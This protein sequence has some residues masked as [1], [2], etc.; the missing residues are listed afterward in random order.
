MPAKTLP[1]TTEKREWVSCMDKLNTEKIKLPIS[2]AIKAINITF[3]QAGNRVLF[4]DFLNRKK[5]KRKNEIAFNIPKI[6]TGV[7]V[8]VIDRRPAAAYTIKAMATSLLRLADL[9]IA[10]VNAKNPKETKVTK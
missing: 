5:D 7:E 3:I 9:F 6:K 10:R 4:F 1:H 2:V 8:Y